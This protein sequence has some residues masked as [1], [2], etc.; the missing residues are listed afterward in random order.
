MTSSRP[1]LRIGDK[2]RDLVA[3]VLQDALAEGRITLEEL[4]QRLDATLRAR[5]YA[6]LDALVADLPVDLPSTALSGARP[7]PEPRPLGGPGSSPDDRLVLDAGWS[8]VTRRGRWDVPPFLRLNGAVGS[9]RLD[10]LQATP[11]A[12]TVDVEIDGGMG[13]I[14]IVLPD[15]WAVNTDRLTSQ[16]GMSSIKVSATPEPGA[17]LLLLHGSVGWGWL[18]VR[19]AG[20]F[21][22]RRLAR[23]AA[24]GRPHRRAL[25]H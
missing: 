15:S 5:T 10:C 6:D 20:F 14:R 23:Q 3:A 4:D 12:P 8:S 2:E 19:H 16:W 11:L 9:V 13:H 18:T 1:E 7:A 21:D 17:P 24:L 22:R 25:G